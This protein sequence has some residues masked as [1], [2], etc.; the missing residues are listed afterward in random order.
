MMTDRLPHSRPAVRTVGAALV[1]LLAVA[2]P[3]SAQAGLLA[4][5]S[6]TDAPAEAAPKS[7]A[8]EPIAAGD[9][10]M[11]ADADE[12]FAQDVVQRTK[13]KDPSK[14]L[15]AELDALTAGIVKLAK[16]F[17]NED[18]KQLL[19]DPARKPRQPLEVLPARAR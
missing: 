9:I 13:G 3:A 12:R 7:T 17:E 11:R 6:K 19:G 5:T 18:L 1:L 15:G 16:A 2:G 8:P 4:G 14:K 10:P